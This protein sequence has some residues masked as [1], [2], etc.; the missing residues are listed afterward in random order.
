MPGS[1]SRNTDAFLP[2]HIPLRP[3]C[4][5]SLKN[6]AYGTTAESLRTWLQSLPAGTPKPQ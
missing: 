3:I 5:C 4:T 1:G 2:H 6:L